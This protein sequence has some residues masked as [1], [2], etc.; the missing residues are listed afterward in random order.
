MKLAT[1]IFMLSSVTG[2]IESF[3][4]AARHG[5]DLE[6]LRSVVDNSQMASGISRVK[7]AKLVARDFSLQAGTADVLKN[8][9]LVSD[10]ARTA[11]AGIPMTDTM[12]RLIE[13]TVVLGHGAEDFTAAL[14]TLEVRDA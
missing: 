5:L 2:L 13:E 8:I 7:S 4:F 14:K 1:N 6:T 3:H 10:A 9:R 12:H 11:G